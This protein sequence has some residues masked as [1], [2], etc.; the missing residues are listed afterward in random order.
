MAQKAS[1]PEEE[2]ETP[3]AFSRLLAFVTEPSDTELQNTE[4]QKYREQ[5]LETQELEKMK[6]ERRKSRREKV[7]HRQQEKLAELTEK[8]HPAVH[9]IDAGKA[10]SRTQLYQFDAT[11]AFYSLE[12]DDSNSSSPSSSKSSMTKMRASVGSAKTAGTGS[13]SRSL[14][15]NFLGHSVGP[16]HFAAQDT[17]QDLLKKYK[18]KR[19]RRISQLYTGELMYH[20]DLSYVW[21][22]LTD[23]S[24]FYDKLDE[25]T[26]MKYP[27][28][29]EIQEK[30]DKIQKRM[31][32]EKEKKQRIKDGR[33]N[34]VMR[35]FRK[36]GK[37]LLHMF[38][39]THLGYVFKVTPRYYQMIP[40]VPIHCRRC[41]NLLKDTLE[42][43]WTPI[44]IA[45]AVLFP[46]LGVLCCLSY[47]EFVCV[48][49][50]EIYMY[51]DY[52]SRCRPLDKS[53][54][55]TETNVKFKRRSFKRA[56]M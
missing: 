39:N 6:K 24:K 10:R 23:H 18:E 2:K 20:H 47:R 5:V 14:H 55:I 26:R 44:G 7:K 29:P 17:E 46:L 32:K 49:C 34:V 3:G 22:H 37:R 28:T 52:P 48:V 21:D 8:K 50:Q 53:H 15:Q 11:G 4:L 19:K 42:V 33:G 38:Q 54:L 41:R 13:D 25:M 56:S 1:K 35:R 27:I 45:F 51:G 9:P 43:H 40:V 12:E 31:E 30:L 36:I 16:S